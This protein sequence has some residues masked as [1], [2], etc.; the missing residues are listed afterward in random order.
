MQP[1]CKGITISLKT[2]SSKVPN[3]FGLPCSMWKNCE[4][5]FY[6]GGSC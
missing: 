3:Q 2:G 6:R 1:Q 5:V 4:K